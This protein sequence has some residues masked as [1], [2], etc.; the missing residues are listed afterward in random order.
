MNEENIEDYNTAENV[1][2]ERLMGKPSKLDI[3]LSM[4]NPAYVGGKIKLIFLQ[5]KNTIHLILYKK[6]T[7]ARRIIITLLMKIYIASLKALCIE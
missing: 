4:Q 6:I 7:T 2:R 3:Y 1:A 5:E